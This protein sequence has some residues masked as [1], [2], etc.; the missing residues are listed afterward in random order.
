PEACKSQAPRRKSPKELFSSSCDERVDDQRY[1]LGSRY[2]AHATSSSP[3]SSTSSVDTWQSNWND[4]SWSSS[5]GYYSDHFYNCYNYTEYSSPASSYAG[6]SNPHTDAVPERD[7]RSSYKSDGEDRYKKFHYGT[8]YN[9]QRGEQLQQAGSTSSSSSA[10]RRAD[11]S[12]SPREQEDLET[13]TELCA[14]FDRRTYLFPAGAME[15]V[16]MP[17]DH[18]LTKDI[19][20]R[21]FS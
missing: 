10:N 14:K 7:D 5:Y 21:D 18:N 16:A 17:R 12:H 19:L 11:H 9:Q 2:S 1:D 4:A 3:G 8:R 6:K 15:S 20:A 13:H